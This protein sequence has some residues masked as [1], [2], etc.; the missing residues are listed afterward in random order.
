[1]TGFRVDPD[2]V[3]AQA[4]RVDALAERVRAAAAGGRPLDLAA[5]GIIGQVFALAVVSAAGSGSTAV[6][7]LGTQAAE[8]ARRLREVAGDYRRAEQ[9]AVAGLDGPR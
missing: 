9:G 2:A 3:D 6:G 5:Y 8:H 4:R 7:Q 1:M